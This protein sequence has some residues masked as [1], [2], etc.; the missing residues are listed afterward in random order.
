MAHIDEGPGE[1]PA[2]VKAGHRHFAGVVGKHP[3]LKTKHPHRYAGA[4]P[5]LFHLAADERRD[6]EIVILGSRWVGD[7]IAGRL[8]RRKILRL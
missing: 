8:L 5:L 7:N 1:I 2:F 4:F 3:S 6:I